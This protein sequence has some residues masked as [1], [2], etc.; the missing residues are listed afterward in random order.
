M[1]KKWD[2]GR[3]EVGDSSFFDLVTFG[4]GFRFLNMLIARYCYTDYTHHNVL[5][6]DDT[7]VGYSLSLNPS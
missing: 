7:S 2:T 3:Q 1:K 6:L 5:S 4:F